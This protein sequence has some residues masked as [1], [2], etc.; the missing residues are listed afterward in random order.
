VPENDLRT[1]TALRRLVDHVPDVVFR[2]RL[3]PE[4]RVEYISEATIRL[5]GYE[6]AEYYDD[7]SLGIDTAHPDDR[8]RLTELIRTG[9]KTPTVL[10][11]HPK[12]GTMIWA[13]QKLSPLFD[14]DGEL[15]GVD[16]VIREIEH[17]A[18]RS[19][20]VRS[21]GGLEVDLVDRRVS[22]NGRPVHLTPAEFKLLTLLTERPGRVVTREEMMQKLWRSSHTGD[23]HT[24]EAHISNLRKK[25]ERDPR[26]PTRIV[27]VRGGGYRFA[28]VP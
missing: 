10:R 21:L 19:A 7:P 9:D 27:T 6:P 28:A 15:V 14:R 13:E 24:C 4:P 1:D 5:V 23:G 3:R 18:R 25:I 11:W 17:P 22:V 12:D 8:A 26:H 16:G 20:V 2:F